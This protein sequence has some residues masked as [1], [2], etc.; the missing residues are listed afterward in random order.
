MRALFALITILIIIL[1]TIF[2]CKKEPILENTPVINK[3][4]Y[5]FYVAGHAYGE[6]GVNYMGIHP[7]FQEYFEKLNNNQEIKFGCFLGDF[8]KSGTESDWAHFNDD[9]KLLTDPVHLVFGNHEYK[10]EDY[11]ETNFDRTYY[12]FEQNNDIHIILDGNIDGWSIKGEQLDFLKSTLNNSSDNDIVFIYAHQALWVG[13]SDISPVIFVN[14]LEGRMSNPNFWSEVMPLLTELNK[15][16][17]L[18][19]GD[20]GSTWSDDCYYNA[21]ENVHFLATGMGDGE[22]D[23]ILEIDVLSDGRLDIDLI[24]LN[25]DDPTSLGA[26][27]DYC[28]K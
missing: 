27:K 4:P 22:G 3:E 5:A 1:I 2:A 20:L 11:I 18:F 23:N 26:Y 10:N 16:V 17:Y 8:V 28:T 7:P 9:L 6:V 15:P 13:N 19:S 12:A 21:Y 14:S 24:A 25:T